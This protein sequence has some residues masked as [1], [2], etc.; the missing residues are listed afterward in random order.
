MWRKLASLALG[1]SLCGCVFRPYHEQVLD[2][3]YDAFLGFGFV[4]EPHVTVVAEALNHKTKA[5]EVIGA[6]ASSDEVLPA[7]VYGSNQPLYGFHMLFLSIANVSDPNS[8]CR[9]DEECKITPPSYAYVRFRQ[10]G[11]HSPTGGLIFGTTKQGWSCF[12]QS[13]QQTPDLR[14]RGEKCGFRDVLTLR[15]KQ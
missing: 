15:L 1:A 14:M 9:W 3:P 7:G 10:I 6:V 8:L 12:F 5:W 11:G 2:G 13:Q 4:S